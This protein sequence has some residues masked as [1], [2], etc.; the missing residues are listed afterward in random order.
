MKKIITFLIV[1]LLKISLK[2]RYRVTFKG[3]KN[4]NK[5]N[6]NKPGGILFLP[7]H[8]CVFVDPTVITLGIWNKYPIRP[9]IV[10]YFYYLP[11]VHT[12]MKFLRAIPMPHHANS[13]NSLKKTISE[14]AIRTIIEALKA[15]DNI[16][17]YPAGRL[18]E[19]GIEKIGGASGAHTIIQ[20]TPEANIVLVRTIGLWGSSFSKAYTGKTP[21]MFP[22]I[23]K[24]VKAVL[25][26]GLFFTPRRNI[27]VEFTPAPA[28]FPYKAS[29]LE[30]NRYLENWYNRPDALSTPSS[31]FP[32][33]TLH[34]VSYSC[35]KEQYLQPLETA[36]K[37]AEEIDVKKISPQVREKIIG[38]LAEL[39]EMPKEKIL[40]QMNLSTDLGL[41]SLDIAD[42]AAYIQEEF[43]LNAVPLNELTSVV[44]VMEIANKQIAYSIEDDEGSVEKGWKKN[45]PRH[46]VSMSQGATIGEVFLNSCDRMGSRFAVGDHLAGALRY[47]KL[48]LRALLLAEWIKKLPGNHI[49]ILLPASVASTVCILACQIAGKVPVMVNWT[50]G[51]RHLDSVVGMSG[52][53]V[54]LSSWSF[55]DRL[56]NVDFGPIEDKMIMLED[57]RREFG[58]R[59]KIQAYFRSKLST[60]KII[61]IFGIDSLNGSETAVMLFTSG[62]E[63]LPKGVPLS[64]QNILSNQKAIGQ[65]I[66]LYS[67]DVI[68]GFLPPFHAFGFTVSCLLGLV[69][70]VKVAYSPDP[71][72]GNKLAKAIEKWHVTMTCGAPTFLKKILQSATKEELSSL[73]I[74]ASGA[75]RAPAEL[76]QLAEQKG[77]KDKFFE[78]YGV[79]E[80][81]PTVTFNA[82]DRPIGGV[83]IPLPGVEICIVHPETI[84]P[85][86]ILERGLILVHGPNVFKGY[87]NKGVQSPFIT[88]QGKEWYSTGDLG[89]LD[90]LNRLTISGRLKRFI[91]I[92]PEMISLGAIE[93]ALLELAK[94]KNHQTVEGPSLA[95]CAKE[96]ND[97]KPKIALFT[98]F[99]TNVDEANQTLK[100]AGFSNLVR[101]SQVHCLEEIP[102]MGTG[103]I[104]YRELESYM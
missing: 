89:Y 63:S 87:I 95:I 9:I 52:V 45:D 54:V 5:K 14:K 18:K 26:N 94:K 91:K 101:I 86:D 23:W 84:K 33:E 13:S 79:T 12:L 37:T 20:S 47:S 42:V 65:L 56:A 83:G 100:E 11:I 81:S 19:T 44:K 64:H 75:E 24:G 104:H 92:G 50:V 66:E 4:L 41:D 60:K 3:L 28:D 31:E 76:F 49:G 71:T 74:V 34:L 30:M 21:S 90:E 53:Q 32:G 15:G 39:A 22:T 16:L 88:V 96:V 93:D 97:A 67:D 8:P 78:G 77:L 102:L 51:P 57:V 27:I 46:R 103:K 68:L 17:F 58:L 25:K 40:P 48:K 6:L 1:L 61:K 38:K 29:R 69:Y 82:P 62:T 10:D 43:E 73:R 80:C 7:N 98:R 70:G 85:L 99:S 36:S 55:I 59:D 72:D 35:W 2:F